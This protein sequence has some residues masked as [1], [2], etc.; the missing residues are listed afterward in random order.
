[1]VTFLRDVMIVVAIVVTLVA[2]VF[3]PNQETSSHP[4]SRD[5]PVGVPPAPI[6]SST[7]SVEAAN[8]SLDKRP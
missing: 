6:T 8:A 3:Y 2:L 1:M 7:A 4:A 5:I